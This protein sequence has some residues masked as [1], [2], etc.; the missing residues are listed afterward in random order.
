MVQETNDL[1]NQRELI[2][3]NLQGSVM[4]PLKQL[5]KDKTIERKKVM[6]FCLA[7]NLINP[8][9]HDSP[10]VTTITP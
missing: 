1:A 10:I 7:N 3:E 6:T 5:V 4:E 2:A 8:S 9:N